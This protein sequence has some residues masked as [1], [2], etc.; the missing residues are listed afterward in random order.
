MIDKEKLIKSAITAF[1]TLVA[2][3][4]TMAAKGDTSA[5]QEKCYGIVRAGMNDCATAKDSCASSAKKD[6]QPDAF[7][8]VPVG[9]CN[10]IVGGQNHPPETP[11]S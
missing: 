7:I 2:T 9:L 5:N 10:K 6:S 8:F 3:N 11:K 1:F 4:T